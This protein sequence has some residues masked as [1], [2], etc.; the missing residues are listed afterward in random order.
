MIRRRGACSALPFGRTVRRWED[1]TL[2]I[3][4]LIESGVIH[5]AMRL[6]SRL[7]HNG[8]VEPFGGQMFFVAPGTLL[9]ERKC[10]QI[11]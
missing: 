10:L 6:A 5:S 4:A 3:V 2:L 11:S 9:P 8:Y 7:S 1:L